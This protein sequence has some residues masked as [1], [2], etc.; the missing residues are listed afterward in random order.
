MK[1]NYCIDCGKE[2]NKSSNYYKTVRCGSCNIKHFHKIKIIDI[3]KINEKRAKDL[4]ENRKKYC[5]VCNKLLSQSSYY[6]NKNK[7]IIHSH[8]GV[9]KSI[10][11]KLAM[12]KAK[13][14]IKLSLETKIKMS[15]TRIKKGLS[16]GKLNPRFGKP[17]IITNHWNQYKGMWMRSGWEVRY[18]KWL[19]RQNIKWQYEPKTFDLGDT[20][21]TP[22]FYLPETN[23]YIEIKGYWRE[24]AKNNIKLFKKLYLRKKLIILEEID[25]K[26]L[27]VL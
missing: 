18:A 2:L 15:E 25:L 21:Y 12:S 6:R 26:K 23:E 1:N 10:I 8:L 19:D 13:K 9:K 11:T 24:K 17:P 16:K 3:F 22:D 20:T 7:C 14:G 27:G 4:K 5:I